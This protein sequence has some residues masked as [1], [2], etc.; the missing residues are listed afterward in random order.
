MVLSLCPAMDFTTFAETLTSGDWE[1]NLNGSE[2][3]ISKYKGSAAEVI[4][5][6]KL[7]NH[8]VTSIGGGTFLHST[9]ITGITIPN[10]VTS[11]GVSAFWGCKELTD[12]TIPDCVTNIGDTAFMECAAL[13]GIT[14][15]GSVK[16]LGKGIFSG[17]TGLESIKVD[18]KNAFYMSDEGVLYD[19]E[20]TQLICYPAKKTGVSFAVP[21]F[22]ESISDYAFEN[23]TL[24]ESVTISVYVK[25]I[26]KR[27]FSGCTGLTGIKLPDSL[28]SI[29][30]RAF[31][32]CI[33]ISDLKLPKSLGSIGMFAFENC[34]GLKSISVPNSAVTMQAIKSPGSVFFGCTGVT[35]LNAP[36]SIPGIDYSKITEFTVSDGVERI[37]PWFGSALEKVTI[38]SSATVIEANAFSEC[39]ES[40]KKVYIKGSN[41]HSYGDIFGKA[42]IIYIEDTN[43]A[44]SDWEYTA[45]EKEAWIKKYK[46][47]AQ[48]VAIPDEIDGYTVTQ[49]Y[50][51]AI[52]S[53]AS[54]LESPNIK[55]IIIPKT[56]RI[57]GV[58]SF[59]GC[60]G[61]MNITV[62]PKNPCYS[63]RDGIV[64]RDDPIEID[65]NENNKKTQIAVFPMG[66]NGS[67]TIPD[68]VTSIEVSAFANCAGLTDITIPDSV[69]RIGYHAF[70]GCTGIKSIAIPN[71]VDEIGDNVF[72]DCTSLVSVAVPDSVKKIGAYAFENC[73]SLTSITIPNSVDRIYSGA[74]KNCTALKSIN[75]PNSVARIE[76]G[77]FYNCTGLESITLPQGC[78]YIHGDAFSCDQDRIPFKVTRKV[79]IKG[80]T[81]NYIVSFCTEPESNIH[82]IKTLSVTTPPTQ[83]VY[84]KGQS[85]NPG[86][87]VVNAE[88]TNG[89]TEK[90]TDY[91]VEFNSLATGEQDVT[92]KCGDKN[93]TTK[94]Y[95]VEA[96]ALEE[97][98]ITKNPTK[99]IYYKGEELNTDG[100]IVTA[101]YKINNIYKTEEVTGYT[102]SG[103]DPAKTGVQTITVTYGGKIADFAVRVFEKSGD[104]KIYT[105]CVNVEPTEPVTVITIEIGYD[106]VGKGALDGFS[107]IWIGENILE[108]DNEAVT[109]NE[110]ITIYGY[111][112]SE[113]E[114]FCNRVKAAKP[115]INFEPIN[116]EPGS[117][118]V[119]GGTQRAMKDVLAL[120]KGIVQDETDRLFCPK[121]VADMNG[122]K[123]INLIDVLILL[124]RLQKDY[125]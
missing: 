63:S 92:V 4:I 109:T 74:F 12:I 21:Y 56:V 11:I 69:E 39:Y 42:E 112:A 66:R 9:G 18:E 121:A 118:C 94:V 60:T 115:N 25:N 119:T 77:T 51:D 33:G 88:Y 54:A 24:L 43:D 20:K 26:G 40:L 75:I 62:D 68:F 71:G 38:P 15:P 96:D 50:G 114:S 90:I 72:K 123:N 37:G 76:Q 3:T 55:K 124:I 59:R 111:A 44:A 19:K 83:T 29:G 48:E 45:V 49:I 120:F 78:S 113:A 67:F 70:K 107:E 35:S 7:D 102:T 34:T 23:C 8:T 61:L 2:A 82:T 58:E 100:L 31:F 5:P 17:C 84:I 28:K 46:G 81:N 79:Y 13:T 32:G 125:M 27:A 122:D 80:S 103:F 53:F 85:F 1:Y 47:S 41:P 98:N 117:G 91:G 110:P 30:E 106:A 105:G 95:I 22:I 104:K 64:Y 57:I 65:K 6:D 97:I 116:F 87:M 86:G 93:A 108:I 10:T 52:G 99:R 89:K 14:I 101:K 16:S 36:E 73:T